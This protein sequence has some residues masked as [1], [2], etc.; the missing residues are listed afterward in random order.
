MM[1]STIDDEEIGRFREA[2]NH[3]LR[4]LNLDYARAVIPHASDEQVLLIALH[5]ARYECKD[6]EPEYR[7]ASGRWLRERGYG[8]LRGPLLPE[9]ELPE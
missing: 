6:I 7:H 2:R 4:E 5:K 1:N 9:G 8:R 3:A